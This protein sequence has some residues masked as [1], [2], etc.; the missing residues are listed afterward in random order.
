MLFK[1]KKVNLKQ[2]EIIRVVLGSSLSDR[3]NILYR[4]CT[5]KLYS[6]GITFYDNVCYFRLNSGVWDMYMSTKHLGYLDGSKHDKIFEDLVNS[7][8]YEVG[9]EVVG[10]IFHNRVNKCPYNDFTVIVGEE[11]MDK[12]T[13]FVRANVDVRSYDVNLNPESLDNLCYYKGCG[14]D[15]RVVVASCG[16]A[17]QM[18]LEVNKRKFGYQKWRP[19]ED[20][21]KRMVIEGQDKFGRIMYISVDF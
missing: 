9:T 8:L 18:A 19:V 1:Q 20:S 16:S 6:S 13:K 17:E 2:K 15:L 3:I 4:R 5:D 7:I 10:I 12:F 21:F 14:R 11:L